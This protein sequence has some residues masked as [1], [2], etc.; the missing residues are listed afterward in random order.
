MDTIT[1]LVQA[2]R[3][4]QTIPEEWLEVVEGRASDEQIAALEA[5]AAHDEE[6]AFLLAAF[7]PMSD[8]S[9]E[10]LVQSL[11][12]EKKV[13][14][15]RPRRR[16]ATAVMT[17]AAAAAAM[18]FVVRAGDQPMPAY[19]LEASTPDL[20]FRGDAKTVERPK[21]HVGSGLAIVLRPQVPFDGD[22]E[23]ATFVE[24]NGART[25]IELPV[26]ISERRAIRV[27]GVVRELL[28]G[29]IGP[30][31]LVFVVGSQTLTYDMEIT[32]D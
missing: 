8:E 29:R 31:T 32:A 6:A 23:V 14:R 30:A 26:E 11:L 3:E 12:P 17:L 28:P 1:K 7:R 19:H 22:V 13:V 15:F 5:R 25:R 9:E 10:A 27:D 21:H 16:I 18:F 20:G 4:E 2:E 24:Q